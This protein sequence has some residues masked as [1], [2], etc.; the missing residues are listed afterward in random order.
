MP[1]PDFTPPIP[2]P[3]I[4]WPTWIDG[5]D[6]ECW[7][8]R[9]DEAGLYE[10]DVDAQQALMRLLREAGHGDDFIAGQALH[11]A[12]GYAC[13][14]VR[15]KTD[16]DR[17]WAEGYAAFMR[18]AEAQWAPIID[19][20]R[21]AGAVDPGVEQTGGMCLAIGF[22]VE[23]DCPFQVILT[24]A[25]G[26]I[27]ATREEEQGAGDWRDAPPCCA[28][29]PYV[30]LTDD[31]DVELHVEFPGDLARVGTEARVAADA[32]RIAR[33]QLADARRELDTP[34]EDR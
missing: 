20:L 27:A 12:T 26:P 29:G 21:E 32:V 17:R 33:S 1:T 14:F 9:D 11:K 2:T 22:R 23:Q 13:P 7:V 16:K 15:P 3:G 10:S 8:Q 28:V 25:D 19:A 4:A 18:E 5:D 24:G 34:Q 30:G 31:A 6:R